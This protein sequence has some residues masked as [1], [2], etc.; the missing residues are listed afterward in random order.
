[1]WL[2]LRDDRK[3]PQ[4]NRAV[5]DINLGGQQVFPVAEAQQAAQVP[6]VILTSYDARVCCQSN[7]KLVRFNVS[8]YFSGSGGREH[9]QRLTGTTETS[10]TLISALTNLEVSSALGL[11]VPVD[12]LV[13]LVFDPE[14]RCANPKGIE[15]DVENSGGRLKVRVVVCPQLV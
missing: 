3:A 15:S 9:A 7:R 8:V 4:P 11:T 5:L 10:G 1:M 13:C 6:F 14:C 2:R 12:S